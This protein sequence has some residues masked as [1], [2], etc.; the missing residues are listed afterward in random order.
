MVIS[1]HN[2]K[3]NWAKSPFYLYYPKFLWI[4]DMLTFWFYATTM[5]NIFFHES[6]SSET[7]YAMLSFKNL[8]LKFTLNVLYWSSIMVSSTFSFWS[9]EDSKSL[10]FFVEGECLDTKHF[11]FSFFGLTS[12]TNKGTTFCINTTESSTGF[13]FST[14]CFS[15]N[16]TAPH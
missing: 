4:R 2:Q 9:G 12:R 15:V 8:L 10:N 6:F 14:F 7:V 16:Y 11:S 13:A 3:W 5:N 1:D